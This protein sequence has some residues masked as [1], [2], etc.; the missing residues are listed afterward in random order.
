MGN[1]R[2]L[3]IEDGLV[4][5]GKMPSEGAQVVGEKEEKVDKEDNN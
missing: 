1:K 5:A 3:R 4:L 2:K